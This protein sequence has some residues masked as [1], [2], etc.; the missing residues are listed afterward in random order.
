[1]VDDRA[2]P[3]KTAAVVPDKGGKRVRA[4]SKDKVVRVPH[5]TKEFQ[6]PGTEVRK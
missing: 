3:A 6:A 4:T 1:M 2:M 5:E